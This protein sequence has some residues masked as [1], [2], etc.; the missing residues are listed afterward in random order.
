MALAD[1][2]TLVPS[3]QYGVVY[4]RFVQGV[5]GPSLQTGVDPN[6]DAELSPVPGLKIAFRPSTKK[7]VSDPH[8]QNMF[9]PL[10]YIAYTDAD[11]F[12]EVSLLATDMDDASVIG[13]TWEV[14]VY[15]RI[16]GD[17]AFRGAGNINLG[18]IEVLANT[19]AWLGDLLT[20]TIEP[21][22][23]VQRGAT[24]P[25]GP[26]GPQGIQGETGAEGAVGPQGPQGTQGETGPEGPTGPQG[27]QGIQGEVGPPSIDIEQDPDTLIWRVVRPTTQEA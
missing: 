7:V 25:M 19:S 5:G 3:A 8:S 21:G 9:S 26:Q 6:P 2:L 17:Y 12:F 4:G 22:V 11:G 14:E 27:P 1:K 16:P 10:D 23:V 20:H 15:N 18:G 13:W 24:G